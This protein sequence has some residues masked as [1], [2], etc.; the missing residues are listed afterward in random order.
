M[1]SFAVAIVGVI[2]AVSY[3]VE[4][5]REQVREANA[6][7]YEHIRRD[8]QTRVTDLHTCADKAQS[9]YFQNLLQA[10]DTGHCPYLD[11]SRCPPI[12]RAETLELQKRAFDEALA[13]KKMAVDVCMAASRK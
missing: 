10:A 12:N 8:E 2:I 7:R 5:D 1:K 4:H 6:L 3:F 11:E 9:E 13:N